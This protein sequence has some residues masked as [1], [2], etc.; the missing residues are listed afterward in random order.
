MEM[1]LRLLCNLF[2]NVNCVIQKWVWSWLMG[3]FIGNLGPGEETVGGGIISR[4]GS[5][6]F[7]CVPYGNSLTARV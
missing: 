7:F 3:R 6:D 2:R 5:L 1:L 4:S